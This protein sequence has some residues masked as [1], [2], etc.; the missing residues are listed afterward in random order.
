MVAV[1]AALQHIVTLCMLFLLVSVH[2]DY[3]HNYPLQRASRL[4]NVACIA[5]SLLSTMTLL[6]P[7][8]SLL[9]L[10]L[11]HYRAV[12]WSQFDNKLSAKQL[13]LPILLIWLIAI[14]TS[15]LWTVFHRHQSG[16]YC[17]PF[18]R[19]NSS[20]FSWVEAILQSMV[21]L[22]CLVSLV[23]FMVYYS[24]M[25]MYLYK[26]EAAVKAMRSKK[27]SNT[28]Q[29]L[30]RFSFTCFL[31]S[32][33]I[34]LMNTTMFLPMLNAK[35]SFQALSYF[36]YIFTVCTTDIYLHCYVLLRRLILEHIATP[37][38]TKSKIQAYKANH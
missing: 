5:H 4:D 15:A 18:I 27:I 31:Q 21:T 3:H 16:W 20:T 12:F 28:K 11:I 22:T 2:H 10:T 17:L 34:L 37:L 7:S 30:I 19:Y 38:L 25:I 13:A 26:E 33:Q 9:L 29:T 23:I 14:T 36:G 35:E 24:K 32:M 6:V 8:S 1:N